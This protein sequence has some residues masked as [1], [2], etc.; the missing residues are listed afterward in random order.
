VDTVPVVDTLDVSEADEPTLPEVV[1]LLVLGNPV[2]PIDVL[3]AVV[4]G[5][6]G[7]S[8]SWGI[9]PVPPT[10][11]IPPSACGSPLQPKSSRAKN[12][13]RSHAIVRV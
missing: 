9:A 13:P 6:M 12:A 5:F 1:V 2:V 7:I 3:D 10:P 11:C 4:D 8:M